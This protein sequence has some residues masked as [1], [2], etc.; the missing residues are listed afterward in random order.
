MKKSEKLEQE[1]SKVKEQIKR[2]QMKLKELEEQK[3]MAERAEKIEFIE[4]N[5]I[6]SE[7]LQMLIRFGE[8]ELK[9][10]LEKK[11]NTEHEEKNI[12]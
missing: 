2:L 4:K 3:H 8:K 12:H 7:Q 6:S 10:L 9:R 1:I 11:E 5:H